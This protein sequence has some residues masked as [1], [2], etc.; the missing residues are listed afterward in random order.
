MT[1]DEHQECAGDRLR[2]DRHRPGRRVR[3]RRH[4]GLPRLREEGKRV[5]LV[6]SNP[7]TIMTDEGV[8]DAVY[9]EPLTVE[10]AASGSSSASGPTACCRRSAGRPASTWPSQLAEAGV[11]DELQR[12]SCSA[13]RSRRSSKA[14]DRELFKQT[15]DRSASR[16][17]RA[18][19]VTTR[20]R[21]RWR[22]RRSD[23]PAAGHPARLHARR[24]R[25]RHRAHARASSTRIARQRP[26]TPARSTRCWSS[27]SCSAGKRS[28]TR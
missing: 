4:A 24:H 22:S 13:R 6:N 25:R 12:A 3:L 16:C 21:R 28:S 27:V 2:A 11:L 15:A 1:R 7:A 8:A 5:I 20:S 19:I 9:I 17:R 26:R 18:A 10:V 23:R 14:E